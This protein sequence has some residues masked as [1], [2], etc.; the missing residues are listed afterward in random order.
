MGAS[1]LRPHVEGKNSRPWGAPTWI[2]NG[3]KGCVRH[4]CECTQ[5]RH[6]VGTEKESP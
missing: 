5:L 6:L 3:T 4:G 2:M 1:F